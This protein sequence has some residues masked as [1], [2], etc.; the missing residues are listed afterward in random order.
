MG[1]KRKIEG[2]RETSTIRQ[3]AHRVKRRIEKTCEVC[4]K[5]FNVPFNLR[6]QRTCGNRCVGGIRRKFFGKCKHCGEDNRPENLQV[7]T[8]KEHGKLHAEAEHIGLS[9]MVADEW[10]PSIEGMAC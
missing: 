2:M 3:R 4:L 8:D 7:V 1:S 6:H 10:V 5:P 9:V